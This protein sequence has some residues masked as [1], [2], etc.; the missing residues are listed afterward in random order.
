MREHNR[1]VDELAKINPHWNDEQLYHNGRK[2]LSAIMQQITYGEFIPRIIGRDYTNR[3]GLTL[4]PNGYFDGYDQQCSGTIF[5][6]FAAAVFRLGHSLLKPAFERLDKNYR[7]VNEPLKLRTA[8]FNSDML[9][10]R[11]NYLHFL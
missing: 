3:F 2:I 11:M 6:E 7:P 10:S 8:F 4:L 5:N 1:L 9:Y